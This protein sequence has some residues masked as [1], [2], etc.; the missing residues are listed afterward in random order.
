MRLQNRGLLWYAKL[1][2]L[3][4]LFA[5]KKLSGNHNANIWMKAISILSKNL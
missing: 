4:A 1:N 2:N 3:H 5:N